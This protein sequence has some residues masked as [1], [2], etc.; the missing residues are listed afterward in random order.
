M[1]RNILL[2]L[3]GSPFSEHALPL[4][5]D[6]AV[7]S[8]AR[9]HL[10]QVHEPPL[11]QVYPDGLPVY[12]DRWDGAI[13]AQTE[14]YLRSVAQRC[15]ERGGVSPVT[16]LLDGSV[17][18]AI[19]QYAAEVGIDLITMTTHGRGG[20]SRAW[21]GSVADSL[22]RRGAVP[23]LLIRPKDQDVD[24]TPRDETRHVL[25]PLDGSELSEGILEPAIVL[26]S[27]IG[28]RYTLLRIV[29]PVPFVVGPQIAGVAFDEGGAEQ[30]RLSAAAYLEG[31]GGRMPGADVAV[32]TVF[33]TI[34]ALGILDFAATHAVDMIA[35]ATHGR[36][37]W[38]RVALGS[39]ADK[40]MRGTMMPVML[41]RPP[42]GRADASQ[43]GADASRAGLDEDQDRE[44]PCP[45][46]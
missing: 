17:A 2:P 1:F 31:L 14:E 27:L 21:V 23:L 20:I 44:D 37:G 3:D 6:L 4:A 8:G 15:M 12:D 33:H 10:V 35:M 26:G 42:S 22:V 11:A 28:A 25:I 16:N 9:L 24:W 45:A 29:L 38:S 36:G 30:S 5:V 7:R 32:E 43:A 46:Q 40:V 39:V 19:A 34:P 18:P 13:R 41:Y